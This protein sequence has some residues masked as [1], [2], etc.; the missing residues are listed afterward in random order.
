MQERSCSQAQGEVYQEAREGLGHQ[1]HPRDAAE[2][3]SVAA[4]DTDEALTASVF[5]EP[6]Q[7]RR[8]EDP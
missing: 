5:T 3:V 2:Y 8:Q 7:I 1:E 4:V 6:G